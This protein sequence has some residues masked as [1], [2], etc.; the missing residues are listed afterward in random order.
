LGLALRKFRVRPTKSYS[1]VAT[2][3]RERVQYSEATP[4]QTRG[5]L[6]LRELRHAL[7]GYMPFALLFPKKNLRTLIEMHSPPSE[8]GCRSRT[9]Y[10]RNQTP[11]ASP[12]AGL[13][14]YRKS[15]RLWSFSAF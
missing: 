13:L 4:V 3:I 2:L 14:C 9:P 10:N 1:A 11:E 8:G 12:R 5:R 7:C 15:T 6:S